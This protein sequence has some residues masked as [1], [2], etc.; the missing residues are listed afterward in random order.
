MSAIKEAWD[1][2]RAVAGVLDKVEA[3]SNEAR[4]LRAENVTLRLQLQDAR[5]RLVRIETIIDEARERAGTRR[6]PRE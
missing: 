5:E 6:L 2:L 4:E 1:T 3:L